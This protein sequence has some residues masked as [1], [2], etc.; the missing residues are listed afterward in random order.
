MLVMH[1]G[2]I[3]KFGGAWTKRR[4]FTNISL[5][6]QPWHGQT[7]AINLLPHKVEKRSPEVLSIVTNDTIVSNNKLI[8]ES[9]LRI[10]RQLEIIKQ[11]ADSLTDP[12]TTIPFNFWNSLEIVS[13]LLFDLLVITIVI[14]MIGSGRWLFLTTPAV[15]IIL[16]QSS[17]F[18]MS[19]NPLDYFPNPM[20]PLSASGTSHIVILI[21]LLVILLGLLILLTRNMVYK[22]NLSYHTAL[23]T[24]SVTSAAR[25]YIE[26][27]LIL[28]TKS[29]AKTH[30][31]LVT[32]RVPFYKELPPGT[33]S[34]I[35]LKE[36]NMFIQ[37]RKG[38]K[39][40]EPLTI[41]GLASDGTYSFTGDIRL[42]VKWSDLTWDSN[43][44]PP[45]FLKG[46]NGAAFVRVTPDPRRI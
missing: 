30:K 2:A 16:P 7:Y 10:R 12:S 35:S 39:L 28:I 38:F 9:Q 34:V 20:D 8:Q 11:A 42:T 37:K 32:I 3:T 41:R 27:S 45:N 24:Q 44:K 19:L 22:V 14:W 15:S 36:T 31:S 26:V 25:F 21:K 6:R 33:I 4:T 13:R 23:H 43:F 5:L 29:F 46:T 40:V 18:E 17:A 1:D